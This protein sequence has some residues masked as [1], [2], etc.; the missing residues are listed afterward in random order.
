M[1]KPLALLTAFTLLATLAACAS[2]AAPEERSAST[3]RTAE[4]APDLAGTWAFDLES[5]D[6]A[7]PLRAKCGSEAAGNAAVEAACWDE[8]RGEARLEKIRFSEARGGRST[9]TSFA[10][11]GKKE[12]VFLEVPIELTADGPMLVVAKIAGT[13]TGARAER[14]AKSPPQ[15]MRIEVVDDRRIA[16]FDP[17]KGRLVYTKE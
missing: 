16:L 13:P 9:W 7:R 1:S 5:S 14:F 3:T 2:T 15:A 6:V 11:D 17:E 10:A 8:L 12:I 4:P